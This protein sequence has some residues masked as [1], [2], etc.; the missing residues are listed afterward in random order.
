MSFFKETSTA[1]EDVERSTSDHITTSGMYPVTLKRMLVSTS[2]VEG[3]KGVEVNVLVKHKTQEQVIYGGTRIKNTNGK[4][5]EIG[6]RVFNAGMVVMGIDQPGDPIEV[7]LP[8]GKKGAKK[9]VS[10]IPNIEDID[11]ILHVQTVY[12]QYKG[13]IS[14]NRRILE[15]FRADQASASEIVNEGEVGKQYEASLEYKDSIRYENDLTPEDI[16]TW[17][18]NGREGG[19]A[20]GGTKSAPAV[21]FGK[22]AQ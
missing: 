20:T 3:N 10:V 8:V 17:V 6:M 16:V 19:V 14:E 1:V 13:K 11:I 2:P 12:S 5:N 4:A 9:R 21:G 7:E 15:I 18:K 22:R